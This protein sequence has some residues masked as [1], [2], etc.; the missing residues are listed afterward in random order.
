MSPKRQLALRLGLVTLGAFIVQVALIS[1]LQPLG[2]TPDVLPLVV[3]SI[4]LLAGPVAGATVG[5]AL[6]LLV[7]F[8]LVQAI[9]V[10]SL[11]FTAIGYGAGRF[12]ELR[13]PNSAL[14]PIIAGAAAAVVAFVGYGVVRF[15]LGLDAPVTWLLLRQIVLV[16]IYGGLLALPVYAITRRLL[17]KVLPDEGKKRKRRAYATGGLSPLSRS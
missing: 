6:G 5:F 15:L 16:I 17:Q 2:V 8:S 13:D 9:G 11:I 10:S 7:D 3:M 4:G 14:V 12:R 1:Q